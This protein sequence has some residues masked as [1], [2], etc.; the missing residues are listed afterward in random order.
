MATIIDQINVRIDP[1]V[2]VRVDAAA[3]AL[4][5]TSSQLVREAVDASIAALE[6]RAEEA[7]RTAHSWPHSI[8]AAA[9]EQELMQL[10]RA[11]PRSQPLT[12]APADIR[13]AR[14]LAAYMLLKWVFAEL[15][16]NPTPADK[17][18]EAKVHKWLDACDL[19][20]SG[21]KGKPPKDDTVVESR[22]IK[23]YPRR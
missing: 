20:K 6:A 11:I 17:A 3:A 1:S 14:G 18:R 16:G 21:G 12:I 10:T 13:G 23:D 5:L 22:P 9:V 8:P 19:P 2:K 15:D 4:G 7:I